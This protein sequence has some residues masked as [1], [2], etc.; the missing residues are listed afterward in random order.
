MKFEISQ[1]IVAGCNSII[2]TG[3]TDLVKCKF[4]CHFHRSFGG[5]KI[6]KFI[7][8]GVV[9]EILRACKILVIFMTK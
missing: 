6:L 1:L 3:Q 7:C 4:H 8:K 5:L 9:L 2:F